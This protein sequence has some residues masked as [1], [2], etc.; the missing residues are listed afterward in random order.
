MIQEIQT[1]DKG[2]RSILEEAEFREVILVPVHVLNASGS[3]RGDRGLDRKLLRYVRM[4][5][6]WYPLLIWRSLKARCFMQD[7]SQQDRLGF[8]GKQS[9]TPSL[10]PQALGGQKI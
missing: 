2:E 6:T 8:Q 3:G 9:P 1:G 5:Y 4:P 7:P 10:L